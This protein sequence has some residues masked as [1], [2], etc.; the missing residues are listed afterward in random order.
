VRRILGVAALVALGW[1]TV[2]AEPGGAA[3]DYAATASADGVRVG[4]AVRRFL[5]VEQFA[6]AG[7]PSAQAHVDSLGNSRAW[8][9]YPFPGDLVV[10]VPGTVAGF[11][12]PGL[13][14][15]PP[16]PLYASA[17]YPTGR[18]AEAGGD[19][20]TLRATAEEQAATALASAGH[21]SDEVHVGA[22][23][24]A[25]TASRKA[26][27]LTEAVGES[28]VEAF[29]V[30]DVL[31]IGRVHSRAAAGVRPGEAISRAAETTVA[32]VAVGGQPVSIGPAGLTTPGGAVPLPD[33]DDAAARQALAQA[34]ISVRYL[35]PLETE[36]GVVA[37]GVE[38][39]LVRDV[40]GVGETVAT[41]VLGRATAFAEAAPEVPVDGTFD[42]PSPGPEIPTGDADGAATAPA[43]DANPAGQPRAVAPSAVAPR[44][45]RRSAAAGAPRPGPTTPAAPL[46]PVDAAA[47]AGD[48]PGGEASPG[49][50]ESA[51]LPSA[52]VGVP[53]P[54]FTGF[55]PILAAGG[56]VVAG[57]VV[58]AG[59]MMRR[60]SWT[61]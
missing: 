11:G 5:V 53:G 37:A 61:S 40:S 42:F 13:P 43:G 47:P 52:Q 22:T 34:G 20:L 4:L 54:D 35:A 12:P 49:S 14:A 26:G 2:P 51:F 56:A 45:P 46:A 31:R 48:P 28:T 50:T 39:S 16:Y 25:A 38:V 58:A 6:D 10:S 7:L 23:H 1:A 17:T 44:V 30:G 21:A 8:A 19:G 24:A 41:Y 60:A 32:E 59:R 55:L 18:E 29:T 33:D 57:A 15:L 36:T 27:S 9:A 3:G